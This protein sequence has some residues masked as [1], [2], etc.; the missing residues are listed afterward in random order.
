MVPAGKEI[1]GPVAPGFLPL[2][3][4]VF[5]G[6]QLTASPVY[7]GLP[8]MRRTVEK[9]YPF[10]ALCVGVG[11]LPAVSCAEMPRSVAPSVARAKMRR[12]IGAVSGSGSS[13]A[14]S[15]VRQR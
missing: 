6:R 1:V 5:S 13:A 2:R 3:R 14:R 9:N 7:D 4:P 11:I 12:M 8:R 10:P 15:S